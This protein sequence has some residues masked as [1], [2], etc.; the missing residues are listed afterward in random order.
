ME[1]KE[2]LGEDLY[3]Q[4]AEAVKGKGANGK[5]IE[6]VAANTGDYVPA[7]KYDEVKNSLNK[8]TIDYT[9]LNAKYE[10]D[11]T[12]V[13]AESDKTLKT[14]ML[15][16]ALDKANIAKINGG[17]DVYHGL[18]DTSKMELEGTT[19]KGL[20][21]AVNNFVTTNANLVVKPQANGVT[22]PAQQNNNIPAANGVNPANGG[23]TIKDRAYYTAAY[24]DSKDLVQKLAIKRE[25]AENG[26]NI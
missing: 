7:K 18:F 25:A 15:D 17:Y 22:P 4:V 14:Y 16:N 3:N 11:V 20:D 26:I 19:L 24:K 12:T 9:A 13:K 21:E 1:L 8:M 6:L 10:Q 23:Q 2:I 5:D